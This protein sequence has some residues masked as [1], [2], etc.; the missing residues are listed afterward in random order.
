MSHVLNVG[1]VLSVNAQLY[2][3]RLAV[4]DLRR[5]LTYAQFEERANRLANAFAGLGLGK[6]DRVAI[7]AHNCLEWMEIYAACAKSGVVAVPVNFRL[8]APEVRYIVEDCGAAVLLVGADLVDVVASLRA[9]LPLRPAAYVQIGGERLAA[10]ASA[11]TR[12]CS[13]F[14]SPRPPAHEGPARGHL[15]AHV[16]VR[17]HRQAEGRDPQPPELRALL[18]PERHRVRLR[19]AT[20]SG[21]R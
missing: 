21:S 1:E 14:G 11:T 2:P 4:K 5:A 12:T 15:D 17:H 10:R 7:Y 19:R 8:T 18:P 16:H 13:R 3:D 20:T 6:G 9:A